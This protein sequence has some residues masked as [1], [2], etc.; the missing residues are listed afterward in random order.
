MTKNSI[1]GLHCFSTLKDTREIQ[2][3]PSLHITCIKMCQEVVLAD[4]LQ[5]MFYNPALEI[6]LYLFACSLCWLFKLKK[7]MFY[8]NNI[9]VFFF[10]CL[11]ARRSLP[12]ALKA[13]AYQQIC[14]IHFS[15]ANQRSQSWTIPSREQQ[16]LCNH[17]LQQ[18]RGKRQSNHHN[19]KPYHLFTMT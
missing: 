18:S 19:K 16:Q 15:S 9:N 3:E 4:Y 14:D 17:T 7:I 10:F 13:I 1:W 5:S 11:I 12:V 8:H 2:Q 6:S